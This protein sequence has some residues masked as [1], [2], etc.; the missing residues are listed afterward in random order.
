M[1]KLEEVELNIE[2]AIIE[3]AKQPQ[4]SVLIA[5]GKPFH[6]FSEAK[7]VQ[8]EYDGGISVEVLSQ[9]FEYLLEAEEIRLI[10]EDISEKKLSPSSMAEYVIHYAMY[11][12][13]PSW[14]SDM[15]S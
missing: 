4:E 6:P 3:V 10:L 8:L 15:P 12:A 14:I 13:Y 1:F 2:Q 11:D 5:K 7:F 9:G